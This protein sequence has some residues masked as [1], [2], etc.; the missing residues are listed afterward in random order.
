MTQPDPTLDALL[1]C[2]V[3]AERTILGAVL[4]DN[5]AWAQVVTHLR[6]DDFSLDSHKRI[7]LRM[8]KL[9]DAGRAVD[10][11]T[12]ANELE[13]NHET[14][15][16]GGVAYL[17]SLT[18]GLPR[19]PAIEE[20]IGIVKDRSVL[21]KTITVCQSTI[22]AAMDRS[23]AGLEVL[24]ELQ[25]NT[26]A[27]AL[28]NQRQAGGPVESFI[29]EEADEYVR[30]RQR[31]TSP[32]IPSGIDWLDQKTG[33]GY[34]H[35]KIALVCARPNVGKTPC[36]IQAAARNASRGRKVVLFSLEMERGEILRSFIPH[37]TDL[38]NFIVQRPQDQT[39]EQHREVLRGFGVIAEWPLSI[40]D[41]RM[42]IDQICWTID[43]ET[44]KG[45]EVLFGLDHFGLIA[46]SGKP[47][48]VRQVYNE[49]SARLRDKMKHKNAA[50]VVLI[51]P[52]KAPN[53]EAA[54]KP[55]IP[56]DIKE[57]GN[58]FE[59]CFSCLIIHRGIDEESGK[60]SCDALLNLAKLRTGG[61]TGSVTAKFNRRKLSFEASADAQQ[62]DDNF[63]A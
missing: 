57:S 30:E 52:R 36:L 20:Y 42:D 31:K 37:V 21:R 61:S 11:V 18:E 44:M 55:P 6:S 34:R 41:G 12:L 19:R 16:V 2:N 46:S 24:G 32:Y 40:Y 15:A 35:G 5:A 17:A 38:P 1:P 50:L 13:N 8:K 62:D 63:F 45:E 29:S 26:E 27:I 48:D 25:K 54:N 3:D 43:R 53:R 33:G 10:I 28:G 58:M 9:A 60:M 49:N 39:E 47:R 14:E 22:E 4:L 56:D 7:A 59:D 23:R 51:Q